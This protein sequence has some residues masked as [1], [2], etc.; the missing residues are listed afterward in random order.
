MD[1]LELEHLIQISQFEFSHERNRVAK[2]VTAYNKKAKTNGEPKMTIAYL[3]RKNLP[4][5]VTYLE[6]L[7]IDIEKDI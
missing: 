7:G 2:S 4:N 3:L 5:F 1:I 6:S